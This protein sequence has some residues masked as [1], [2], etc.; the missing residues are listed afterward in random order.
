MASDYKRTMFRTVASVYTLLFA[1]GVT[2]SA[3]DR[4][5][6]PPLKT[7]QLDDGDTFV[8]LGD[9]ITHQCLYTQYFEDYFFT[10]YPDR[11]IRFHNSGVGGD[12]VG[13]A[14]IRF[15]RDVAHYKPKYVSILLGMNDGRY[16]AF[17]QETFDV[18]REGMM[19]LIRRIRDLGATPILMHPTMFDSRAAYLR[20]PRTPTERATYYNGVLAYYGAWLREVAYRDGLGYVDMYSWLNL[21]TFTRRKEDPKF[22]VIPDAVHPGPAGQAVMA[23]AMVRDLSL[24]TRVWTAHVAISADSPRV[25]AA[26]QCEISDLQLSDGRLSFILRTAALPW[27]L[28]DEAQPGARLVQLGHR[29]ARET[30]R[31]SG[32]KPGLYELR[33]NGTRVGRFRAARL[34]VGLELQD[35]PAWPLHQQ[36]KKVAELNKA[37]NEQAVRP[38]RNLWSAKKRLRLVEA[39]LQQNP[40][41]Q[42]LKNQAASLRKRLTDFEQQIEQ[43][44]AKSDEFLAKIYQQNQPEPI[45]ITLERIGD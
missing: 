30:L 17:D 39:A 14:L 22:T 25:V 36:A 33:A 37:R 1:L 3:Q 29:F 12:R 31:V 5:F 44:E 18:Y 2:L 32:L 34:G 23:A 13:D 38:L 35:R 4:E 8:F 24:P 11:R 20:N 10:R 43:L 28:P 9:S 45:T 7:I 26:E 6:P 40:D 15:Q 16:Q 27:I 21:L 42:R 41:D 19:E